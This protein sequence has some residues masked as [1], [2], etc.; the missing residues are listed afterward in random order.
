VV[1]SVVPIAAVLAHEVLADIDPIWTAVK[2]NRNDCVWIA[3]GPRRVT[4]PLAGEIE[5]ACCAAHGKERDD[6][7]EW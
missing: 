2:L 6:C 5:D 7:N 1:D 4:N 3:R